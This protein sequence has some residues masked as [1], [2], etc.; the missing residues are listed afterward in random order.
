MTICENGVYFNQKENALECIIKEDIISTLHPS[1]KVSY[2]VVN[3]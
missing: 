3:S 1:A 2:H